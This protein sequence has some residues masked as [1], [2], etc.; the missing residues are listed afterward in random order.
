MAPEPVRDGIS[1]QDWLA[2]LETWSIDRSWD[3][4]LGPPPDQPNNI[5]ADIKLRFNDRQRKRA[6]RRRE[7]EAAAA[8]RT[9][10]DAELRDKLIAATGGNIVRTSALDDVGP[11]KLA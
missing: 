11:I 4:E 6:E 3:T 2:A 5:P 9:A 7:A 8:K 10:A 1:D